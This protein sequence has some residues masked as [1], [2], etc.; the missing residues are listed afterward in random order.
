MIKL[1][2]LIS[3]KILNCRMEDMLNIY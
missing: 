1:F 3:L 2:Y